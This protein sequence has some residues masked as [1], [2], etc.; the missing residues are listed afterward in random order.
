MKKGV[1]IF[2]SIFIISIIVVSSILY[3]TVF[4]NRNESVEY[5]SYSDFYFGAPYIHTIHPSALTVNEWLEDLYYLMHI[6]KENYPFLWVRERTHDY[7]WLDLIPIYRE[8]IINCQSNNEFLAMIN[9]LVYALQNVH[10]FLVRNEYSYSFLSDMYQ[11]VYPYSYAFNEYTAQAYSYWESFLSSLSYEMYQ[12]FDLQIVYEKGNYSVYGASSILETYGIVDGSIIVAVNETPID[13]AVKQVFD[14]DL[15]KIDYIR[16]KLYLKY[17]KPYHFGTNAI[18][19]IKLNNSTDF[20]DITLNY[21]YPPTFLPPDFSKY[22]SNEY[23]LLDSNNAYMYLPTFSHQN[24]IQDYSDMIAFYEQI[25]GYDNLIIDIRDNTG[26]SIYYW[27]DNIIKPLQSSDLNFSFYMAYRN[28]TYVNSYL[29]N[30]YQTSPKISKVELSFLPAEVY[31]DAFIDD[32]HI[33]E[34][35]LPLPTS[36]FNFTGNISLIVDDMTYSASEYLISFCKQTGFAK[37]YGTAGGGDGLLRSYLVFALPNSKLLI[38]MAKE[39]GMTLEG[40]INEEFHTMPD[41]YYES[42]FNDWEELINY[43]KS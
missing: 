18:Y 32:I 19:K 36:N 7:N 5:P 23:K 38:T 28:G 41:V 2:S 39:C 30:Y 1:I 11:Y 3:V 34:W 13:E 8:K 6:V 29:N 25:E 15:L 40:E 21:G 33:W 20:I 17:L 12:Y 31:T 24:K 4:Q 9:D 42:N 14:K 16:N 26:G 37:I 35:S 22:S 10:S 27:M 43:I